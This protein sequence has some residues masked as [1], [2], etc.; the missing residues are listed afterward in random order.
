[1]TYMA[2]FLVRLGRQGAV[3]VCWD[4]VRWFLS[5]ASSTFLLHCKTLCW[6]FLSCACFPPGLSLYWDLW[7]RCFPSTEQREWERSEEGQ[8]FLLEI[9]C[10]WNRPVWPDGLFPPE[11]SVYHS[12]ENC[13]LLFLLIACPCEI[14][15]QN[16]KVLW[17]LRKHS[18]C[19]M[20]WLCQPQLSPL[21]KVHMRSCFSCW[22]IVQ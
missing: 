11:T 5:I 22:P 15:L 2:V 9:H 1:M 12:E 16:W 4:I 14:Y 3:M 13:E 19:S 18:Y 10:T 20:F 6:P 17:R 7:V 8:L 21:H